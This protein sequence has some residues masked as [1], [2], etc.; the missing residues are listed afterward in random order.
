MA[1]AN[2][3]ANTRAVQVRAPPSLT[4]CV[5][6]VDRAT[7]PY[8][9]ERPTRGAIITLDFKY[10]SN[11]FFVEN[12]PI[13]KFDLNFMI[14]IEE[15]YRVPIGIQD[16]AVNHFN[17]DNN[18]AELLNNSKRFPK[19]ED[20]SFKEG[21]IRAQMRSPSDYCDWGE[22][23]VR[24]VVLSNIY[25]S[26][27]NISVSLST[28]NGTHQLRRAFTGASRP[29]MASSPNEEKLRELLCW[30]AGLG[31]DKL[32]KAY[33][34]QLPVGLEMEDAFGM[35]PFSWAAQNGCA[36]V[37][38]LALQQAGSICARRRTARG[39]A[40]L[41]AAAR[42]KN[43][44]IFMSFLKWL[45]YLEDPIASDTT[46]E[47]DEIPD[48]VSDLVDEDIEREIHSAARSEQTVT[49][50]KLIR[51]LCKK[52]GGE[53]EQ[54]DW[55]AN[56]MV[57]AAKDGDLY[58][59]QVLRSCGAQVNCMDDTNS[60]PLAGAIKKGQTKVAEYL[61]LQGAKDDNNFALRKA[62]ENSH[63]STVR[64]LLKVKALGEGG[65]KTDLLRIATGNKD[66]TT[67]MLLKL[68][69]GTEKLA[70]PDDLDS[71]VDKLFEATVVDFSEDRSPEFHEL[72][73]D[74]LMNKEETFFNIADGSTFKWFHLPA[75]NMKWAEN[76]PPKSIVSS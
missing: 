8:H 27:I 66:S 54:K 32:F 50:Q 63:H 61:I 21:T 62:V 42:S 76:L 38:R 7:A 44:T 74:E 55:L 71:S 24:F 58:L 9:N 22:N 12:E 10:P 28:M 70:T 67:L 43:E 53:N 40:P 17:L 13:P 33:L 68:E 19:F 20:V 75:N 29:Y 52:Q 47:A 35:T 59:V 37:V 18:I 30:T 11:I 39:P 51:M 41:E 16:V 46:P 1:E 15:E 64:A 6:I 73:V 26:N 36:P 2:S 69:K 23:N 65:I 60:T 4:S 56:K 48:R 3:S 31:Y 5:D 57:E 72:T 25:P 45:K 49:I 14:Q 34:D